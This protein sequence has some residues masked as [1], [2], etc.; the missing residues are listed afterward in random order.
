M[1]KSK[2]PTS[3]KYEKE[4]VKSGLSFIG[5]LDEVGRGPLAGPV[6]AGFVIFPPDLEYE[7][8]AE[9]TDS[10]KLSATKR[11]HLDAEIRELALISELGWVSAPEIDEIGISKATKLAMMRAVD[12]SVIRPEHLLVDALKLEE[13]DVASTSIVKGDQISTSIAAASIIA[14]VARD[15]LMKKLDRMYPGYGFISNK[16]YGTKKHLEAI[17]ELGATTEH[18]MT[19]APLKDMEKA[20]SIKPETG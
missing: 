7:V 12:K 19:F 20:Y 13:I 1:I 14:K 3:L 8:V 9:I 5:G 2:L 11:N 4:L 6:T 18:R 15:S 16:G 10:K 17:Y